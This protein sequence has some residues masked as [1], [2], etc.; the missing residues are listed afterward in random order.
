MA[1]SK[2]SFNNTPQ[3]GDDNYTW[4][5]DSLLQAN[6]YN[7]STGYI[8]LDVMSNDLG[9]NAK[10]L[11]SIDDGNGNS[12]N[13]TD[14]L[15]AD[16]LVNGVSAWQLTASGNFARINNGKI[17]LN[18]AP[19]L[20]AAG[21]NGLNEGEHFTD[22]FV[23]AIRLGNGTLSWAHVTID[24]YGANDAATITERPRAAWLRTRN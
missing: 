9:G 8:T 12:L 23:Y 4:N 14:L 13:P 22:E 10:T 24:I 5:E 20:G 1:I 11:Y 3:A 19:E 18:L 7:A 17:E 2:V 15:T 16:T 6:L 21:I